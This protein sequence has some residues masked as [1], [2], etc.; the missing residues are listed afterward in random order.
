M[1]I[2]ELPITV[3]PSLPAHSWAEHE[4]LAQ[5][6]RGVAKEF[7]IDLVDGIFVDATS[8]PF[9]EP[10]VEWV[11]LLHK[12]SKTAEQYLVEFDCMIIE[13]ER[14][15]DTL[16]EVGAKRMIVHLGSTDAVMDCIAHA[17]AHGYQLGLALTN[18][19]PLSELNPFLPHIG[20]VQ[21]MGI[22]VVGAQGQAFDVRTVPRVEELRAAHPTL[23][24]A[25]D[26]SVN[27]DTIPILKKAGVNRFAP[28]SAIAKAANPAAA[29]RELFQLALS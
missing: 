28:G 26:G 16:V 17:K 15:L 19:I 2:G 21:L 18:D 6:L 22:A 4:Q 9:M 11:K 10:K 14:Y 27:E 23:E 5:S 20:F 8:W 12:F 24:I 3:L 29:Y 1:K 7:Q 25:V 13:P